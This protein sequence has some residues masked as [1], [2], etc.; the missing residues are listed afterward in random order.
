MDIIPQTTEKIKE[1]SL[2]F[3]KKKLKGLIETI[4]LSASLMAAGIDAS[5]LAL[6]VNTLQSLQHAIR[7]FYLPVLIFYS[8]AFIHADLNESKARMKA[9][10]II[11]RAKQAARFDAEYEAFRKE[12]H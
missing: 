5:M 1:R 3:V 10:R 6:S 9:E 7:A 4:L 11:C 12:M 2:F 8:I